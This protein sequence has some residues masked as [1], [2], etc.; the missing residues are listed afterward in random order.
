MVGWIPCSRRLL[1]R[2]KRETNEKGKRMNIKLHKIYRTLAVAFTL[3]MATVPSQL[4]ADGVAEL[5]LS[6]TWHLVKSDDAKISCPIAV[7]G[8][9]HSA[10][11]KAK[12]IEDSFWGRNETNNL[13]VGK[14]SWIVSRK[15]EVD[16]DLLAKTALRSRT[17]S[18]STIRRSGGRTERA[19][20]SSTPTRWT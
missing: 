12:I 7:P 1:L 20:R 19:S 9:V 17:A 14:S 2:T 5:D 4:L 6:G 13:W 3:C 11:L 15:F 10:L 16:G 18:K 8:G